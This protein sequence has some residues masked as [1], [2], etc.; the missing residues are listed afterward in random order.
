MLTS[1]GRHAVIENT[2]VNFQAGLEILEADRQRVGFRV[3]H[4]QQ[5]YKADNL[6]Q[7][8]GKRRACRAHIQRKNKNRVENDVQDA[9]GGDADH[10]VQGQSLKAEQVI[11]DE[12]THHK[13]HGIENV[14]RV[15][16][17]IGRD[18]RS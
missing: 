15:C 14:G 10:A 7:R 4:H 5:N 8:S 11:H 17:G 18:G 6:R 9:A 16:L 1:E 13:R 12:G 3:A 2:A